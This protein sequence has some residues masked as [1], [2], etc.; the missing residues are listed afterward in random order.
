MD[1]KYLDELFYIAKCSCVLKGGNIGCEYI[2]NHKVPG[3]VLPF[4]K[5]QLSTRQFRYGVHFECTESANNGT[6]TP[7]LLEQSG[8]DNSCSQMA[9]GSGNNPI[10]SRKLKVKDLDVD[11]VPDKINVL[12]NIT[13]PNTVA[14]ID[15]TPALLQVSRYNVSL[16]AASAIIN[17]AY[18]ALN[19]ITPTNK[20]LVLTHDKILRGQRKVRK[21]IQQKHIAE[22]QESDIYCIPSMEK[23]T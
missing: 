19:I 5:D 15:L 13:L 9:I 21:K 6:A 4:L 18:E 23:T 10:G 22:I 16:R 2:A 3:S 11:Y 12:K 7:S 14:D 8:G 1:V 17:G 20:T